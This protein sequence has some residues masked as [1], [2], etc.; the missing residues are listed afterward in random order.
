[1]QLVRTHKVELNPNK[2]EE[3]YFRK[4]CGVQRFAYNWGLT[5]WIQ[6]H[7]A[8]SKPNAYSLKKRFNLIKLEQFPWIDEVSKTLTAYSFENLG[9]AFKRFFQK[10]AKYPKP[11]KKGIHDSFR[12]D[13][14]VSKSNLQ[15]V[16]IEGKRLKIPR[17]GWV[18]MTEPLRFTGKIIKCTVSRT[19]DR[20]FAA[21]TVE[22]EHQIPKR[23][24]QAL[25]CVDQAQGTVGVDLGITDFATL[26]DGVVFGALKAMRRFDQQRRKLHRAVGRKQKGS[27]NRAKARMR[28]ARLEYRIACCRKDFIHKITTWLVKNY[29]TVVIESLAIK[30]MAHNHKL[31]KAI[32]DAGWGEFRRQLLYKSQLYDCTVITAPKRF[33][34]TQLC[35]ACGFRNRELTLKD[36]QWTCPHCG[37]S[38]HR[39]VN[40][41]INLKHLGSRNL[42]DLDP[43]DRN[44]YWT[45]KLS[46][47]IN[48][49]TDNISNNVVRNSAIGY[50]RKLSVSLQKGK[51][52]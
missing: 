40:A 19:A 2:I 50:G 16:R 44:A 22:V 52:T 4:A 25:N 27:A 18:K 9:I 37:A 12:V 21:I 1:M 45:D 29:S 10:K 43:M 15:A 13:N 26:S 30:A 7:N 35:S 8:G 51:A 17:L 5:E 28:L 49:D 34:S 38:H 6:Q 41:A 32:M 11:H 20:W 31:A 3:T 33:P 14:G 39:D 47:L 36:R 24:S 46:P 48:E 23:E 42:Q